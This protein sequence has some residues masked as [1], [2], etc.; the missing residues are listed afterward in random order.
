MSLF[1]HDNVPFFTDG[2]ESL[3]L[4]RIFGKTFYHL[5]GIT[6]PCLPKNGNERRSYTGHAGSSVNSRAF[7][8]PVRK[9]IRYEK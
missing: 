9:V 7:Y 4:P 6:V 1:F 5:A 8:N 3:A 2:L